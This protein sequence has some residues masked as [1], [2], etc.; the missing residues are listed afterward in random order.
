MY[1]DNARSYQKW[2]YV[3]YVFYL[4]LGLSWFIIAMLNGHFN[5][6]ALGITII[7]GAQFYYKH[8]LTNLVLGALCLFGSIFM[9]LQA[10]NGAVIAAKAHQLMFADKFLVG[11]FATSL[12]MGGVLIFSYIKLGFKD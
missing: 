3:A 9:L 12:L 7:F 5:A 6:P 2:V 1:N 4:L 8:L 11:L 10:I